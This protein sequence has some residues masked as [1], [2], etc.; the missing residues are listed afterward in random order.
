MTK[1]LRTINEVSHIAQPNT[2][3]TLGVYKQ[4]PPANYIC[5]GSYLVP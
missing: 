5:V 2:S 1:K 3:S 4:L